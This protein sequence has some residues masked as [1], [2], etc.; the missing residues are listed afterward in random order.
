MT[1]LA[2]KNNTDFIFHN[3]VTHLAGLKNTKFKVGFGLM[4]EFISFH[5]TLFILDQIKKIYIVF[6]SFTIYI[7]FSKDLAKKKKMQPP[8]CNVYMFI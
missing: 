2:N 1:K 5:T 6:G 7:N 8:C 3:M 4:L